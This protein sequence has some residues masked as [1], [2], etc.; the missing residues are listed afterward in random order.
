MEK[1]KRRLENVARWMLLQI[2]MS[3][4]ESTDEKTAS[5]PQPGGGENRQDNRRADADRHISLTLAHELNNLLTVVQGHAD[6]LSVKHQEDALLAPALKKISE[7]AHRAA[8]LVR[9]APKLELDP[10][11]A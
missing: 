11:A 1:W 8:E 5:P 7:A 9:N 2:T 10:P 4:L 6:R 3:Y